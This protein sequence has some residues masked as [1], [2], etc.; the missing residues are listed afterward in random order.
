LSQILLYTYKHTHARTHTYRAHSRCMYIVEF[1]ASFSLVLWPAPKWIQWL[2][3]D[4]L[5]PLYI[6]YIHTL[7]Y[8]FVC[9]YVRSPGMGKKLITRNVVVPRA[10]KKNKMSFAFLRAFIAAA[11]CSGYTLW[12]IV[13]IILWHYARTYRVNA[14]SWNL[15]FFWSRNS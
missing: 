2:S 6:Y 11:A 13:D 5:W 15:S 3:R 14:E 8:I 7:L 12:Y 4:L 9:M 10:L 1:I